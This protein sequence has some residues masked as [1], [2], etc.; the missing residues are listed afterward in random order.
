MSETQ[1][2]SGCFP[3]NPTTTSQLGHVWIYSLKSSKHSETMQQGMQP[4]TQRHPERTHW[5]NAISL[6]T[7]VMMLFLQLWHVHSTGSLPKRNLGS[8]GVSG[9][10]SFFGWL[11]FI[12][13]SILLRSF[14]TA[15]LTI[16]VAYKIVW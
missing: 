12:C 9:L 1:N 7:F 16:L 2:I 6:W 3:L 5:K 4:N 15:L 8:R 11:A 14:R 13:A 10:F